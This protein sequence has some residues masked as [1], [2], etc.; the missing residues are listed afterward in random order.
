MSLKREH[1]IT[2]R[3]DMGSKVYMNIHKEHD[4]ISGAACWVEVT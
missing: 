1:G 3:E 2:E 4:R